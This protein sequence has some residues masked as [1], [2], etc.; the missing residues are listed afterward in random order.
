MVFDYASPELVRVLLKSGSARFR[1]AEGSP[2]EK[3]F[4]VAMGTAGET[5]YKF[6]P[7]ARVITLGTDVIVQA[8]LVETY[9]LEGEVLFEGFSSSGEGSTMILTPGQ[10]MAVLPDGTLDSATFPSNTWWE[11]EF[12][13]TSSLE[14]DMALLRGSMYLI[15]FAA[16]WLVLAVVV[17]GL[18]IYNRRSRAVPRM[19][20]PVMIGVLC[21]C[22]ISTCVAG[23]LSWSGTPG[24]IPSLESPQ[25]DSP[26][27]PVFTDAPTPTFTPVIEV[28]GTQMPAPT[29]QPG[30]DETGVV[31]FELSNETQVEICYIFLSPSDSE[32]WGED[33][34]G[35]QTLPPDYIL[36][37]TAPPRIYDLQALD[38]SGDLVTE[39][40]Q[41]EVYEGFEWV[42][43]E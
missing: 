14:T 5:W 11:D 35:D 13:D 20:I 38:C 40:Y 3:H 37:V 41:Q 9:L 24:Q 29:T 2:G 17:V 27:S 12:Y 31:A 28:I 25:D 4:E 18:L 42:L 43:V 8:D 33:I 19:V 36:P 22:T 7:R 6:Q 30:S 16:M 32:D 34:L 39:V 15:A 10:A 23:V 21:I 26:Q 1:S